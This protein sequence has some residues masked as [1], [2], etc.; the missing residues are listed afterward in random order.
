MI[1][2]FC[3]FCFFFGLADSFVALGGMLV[4]IM[5]FRL[6]CLLSEVMGMWD[7]CYSLFHVSGFRPAHG[8]AFSLFALLF[9]S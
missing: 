8:N 7:S 1:R 9:F 2:G 5:C 4:Y 6:I 3:V